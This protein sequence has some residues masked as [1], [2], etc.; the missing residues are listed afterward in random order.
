MLCIDLIRISDPIEKVLTTPAQAKMTELTSRRRSNSI[1][2]A[3]AQRR[4]LVEEK[5]HERVAM[6][7]KLYIDR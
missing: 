5:P 4:E 3:H 1:N 2:G 7:R 6:R